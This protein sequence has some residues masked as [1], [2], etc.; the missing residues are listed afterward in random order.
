MPLS[1]SV[2]FVPRVCAESGR[3]DAWLARDAAGCQTIAMYV[4]GVWLLQCVFFHVVVFSH[5]AVFSIVLSAHSRW[6]RARSP[7]MGDLV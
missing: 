6:R 4:R 1:R 5:R 7:H 2:C 3:V